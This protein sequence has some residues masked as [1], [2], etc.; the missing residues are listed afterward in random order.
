MFTKGEASFFNKATATTKGTNKTVFVI[1]NE[2]AAK[3]GTYTAYTG[4]SNIP[5]AKAESA[6]TKAYVLNDKDGYAVMAVACDV[7]LT[8]VSAVDY[9]FVGAPASTVTMT[10][11]SSED[12]YKYN[13]AVVNGEIK[14]FDATSDANA[15]IPFAP[16]AKDGI[17]YVLGQSLYAVNAYD[18][19][20]A[21]GYMSTGDADYGNLRISPTVNKVFSH[22][23]DVVCNTVTM[24]NAIDA[25]AYAASGGL[26]KTP[27]PNSFVVS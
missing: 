23:F 1:E 11:N 13:Y 2:A 6:A 18:N 9:V 12:Y 5:N 21:D 8:N 10:G 19:G 14:A 4:V 17:N 22:T 3:D 24:P 26:T 27:V 20:R 16:L 25:F 7:A 15:M